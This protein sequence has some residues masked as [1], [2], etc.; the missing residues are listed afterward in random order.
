MRIVNDYT[1]IFI[2]VCLASLAVQISI[3][4]M[5]WVVAYIFDKDYFGNQNTIHW[6]VLSAIPTT[7]VITL[8]I[9]NK[10][11][12]SKAIDT[13]EYYC[14]RFM[15]VFIFS[16]LMVYVYDKFNGMFFTTGIRQL[17]T[18]LGEIG[19]LALC[20]RFYE[21][22][23]LMKNFI[24]TTQ[25]T[26]GILILFNRYTNLAALTLVVVFTN[27]VI[28]A[29]GHH[30][31]LELFT[32]CMLLMCLYLLLLDHK[33]LASVFIQPAYNSSL[34]FYFRKKSATGWVVT[35]VIFALLFI[36]LLGYREYKIT[37]TYDAAVL[38][39]SG[40]WNIETI[41]T[42]YFDFPKDSLPQKLY[43]ETDGEFKMPDG[44]IKSMEI[45]ADIIKH[46]AIL[47]GE[48]LR[49]IKDTLKLAFAKDKLLVFYDKEDSA[50]LKLIYQ[51]LKRYRY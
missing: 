10:N 35:E 23:P 16:V 6:F 22:S 47:H 32:I 17:D 39:I 19:G 34:P 49:N 37:S 2:T 7:I 28:I 45:K 29:F 27:I 42:N 8:F 11:P 21:Y 13:I 4:Y 51:P 50:V 26:G 12:K 44:K 33:R 24:I 46:T 40:I 15:R 18:P 5:A 20:W 14:S 31:H 9:I 48:I 38:P 36:L 1:R 43:I 3:V 41:N 30:V 25:L